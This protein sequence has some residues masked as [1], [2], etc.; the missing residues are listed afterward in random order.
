MFSSIDSDFMESIFLPEIGK[1]V[2]KIS[3]VFPW[4]LKRFLIIYCLLLY[5]RSD[6]VQNLLQ[7]FNIPQIGYSATSRD[8]S[9]KNYYKYFLRVVPSDFYQ[10]KVMIDL[11]LSNN[12]TYV[13]VLYTD[14]ALSRMKKK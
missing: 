4:Q 7:L 11:F 8:L 2:N 13:S 1:A 6:S 10:A 5:N 14:V 12:W 3:L 9:E